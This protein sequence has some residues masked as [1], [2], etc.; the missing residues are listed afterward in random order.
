MDLLHLFVSFEASIN[1]L[2]DDDKAYKKCSCSGEFSQLPQYSSET[3]VRY[4]CTVMGQVFRVNPVPP[5]MRAY[6]VT[7]VVS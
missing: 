3:H 2:S 7:D 6:T 1:S 5:E 4:R